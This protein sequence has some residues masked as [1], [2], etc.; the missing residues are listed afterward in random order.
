M[1]ANRKETAKQR[2]VEKS[3]LNILIKFHLDILIAHVLNYFCCDSK[4]CMRFLSNDNY[5]LN[6]T[7]CRLRGATQFHLSLLIYIC[8]KNAL[9]LEHSYTNRDR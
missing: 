8:W 7:V 3:V 4:V 5:Q 6:K 2:R 9:V 1:A